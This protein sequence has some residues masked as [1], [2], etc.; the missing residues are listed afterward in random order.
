MRSVWLVFTDDQREWHEERAA[1]IE[2][3]GG[4]LQHWAE[5]L[6]REGSSGR[7]EA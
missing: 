6:R 5:D 7:L 4:Q 2:H 3:M 1:I